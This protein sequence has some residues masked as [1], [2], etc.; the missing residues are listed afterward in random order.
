M[1]FIR[2]PAAGH[3]H[4]NVHVTLACE[5]LFVVPSSSFCPRKIIFEDTLKI[6]PV[7]FLFLLESGAYRERQASNGLLPLTQE[8]HGAFFGPHSWQQEDE[9]EID[10]KRKKK[11]VT[12]I[13]QMGGDSVVVCPGSGDSSVCSEQTSLAS[14]HT[15]LGSANIQIELLRRPLHAHLLLSHFVQLPSRFPCTRDVSLIF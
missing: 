10:K 5:G 15:R 2:L 6:Q 7:L 9:E 11:K 3:C 12:G 13:R 4:Q 14:L 1:M 8:K